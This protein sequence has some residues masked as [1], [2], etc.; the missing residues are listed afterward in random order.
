MN[1]AMNEVMNAVERYL[2]ALLARDWDALRACLSPDV[3]RIGPYGDDYRG[4]EPY[5]QF[6]TAAIEALPGYELVV[7]RMFG[8]AGAI[9][10]ELSETVDEPAGRLRTA[11]AI[12]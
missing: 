3:E 1:D 4:R 9:V 8:D 5:V 10:V 7:D 12:V 6:L 11:E 2:A